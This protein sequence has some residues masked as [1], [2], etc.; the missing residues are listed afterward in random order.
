MAGRCPTTAN[1][2]V[3]PAW[4]ADGATRLASALCYARPLRALEAAR[5]RLFVDAMEWGEIGSTKAG[6]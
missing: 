3:F 4:A 6:P 1:A 2:A 5:R